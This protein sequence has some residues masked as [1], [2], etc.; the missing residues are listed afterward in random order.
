VRHG[1]MDSARSWEEAGFVF[2]GMVDGSLLLLSLRERMVCGWGLDV[3]RCCFWRLVRVVYC[4]RLEMEEG[5]TSL[6]KMLVVSGPIVN[7]EVLWRLTLSKVNDAA[8]S[9]KH[10]RD[11]TILKS[12]RF[13]VVN[14]VPVVL[15]M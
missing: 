1:A 11:D 6:V 3:I 10:V 15:D 14:V 5:A 7:A 13:D 2:L 9:H 8:C 4:G 12:S